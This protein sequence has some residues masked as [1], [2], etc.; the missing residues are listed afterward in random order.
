M[1]EYESNLQA[2]KVELEKRSPR[3]DVYLPLMKHTFLQRREFI[4]AGA[5]SC[6]EVIQSY[7]GLKLSAC[8]SFIYVFCEY[9]GTSDN[10]KIGEILYFLLY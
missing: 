1:L 2:L 5:Q 9:R 7:P 6:S 10:N 3:K 4:L 8:V